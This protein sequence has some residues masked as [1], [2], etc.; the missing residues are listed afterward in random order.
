[1]RACIERGCPNLTQHTRCTSHERARQ[2]RRNAERVG[3]Y[4]AEWDAHS[5]QRRA[6]EPVCQMCGGSFIAGRGPL[7][8]TT[9]HPSDAVLHRRC[10]GRLEARR[11]ATGIAALT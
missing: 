4:D 10:H 1:M 3:F 6:E 9:D 8:A 7:S 5:R 11:R 2:Q